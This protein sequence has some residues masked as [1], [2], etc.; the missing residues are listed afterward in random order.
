M[1]DQKGYEVDLDLQVLLQG[2]IDACVEV[3]CGDSG[4]GNHEV[5]SWDLVHGSA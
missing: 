3:A 1:E 5:A 2:E 4:K